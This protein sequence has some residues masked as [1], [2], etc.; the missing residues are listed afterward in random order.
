MR[1]RAGYKP[2][3]NLNSGGLYAP[4]V[5]GY[6]YAGAI[7]NVHTLNGLVGVNQAIVSKKEFR[8][9]GTN[10]HVVIAIGKQRYQNI[11][12]RFKKGYYG[13]IHHSLWQPGGNINLTRR[14][15]NC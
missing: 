10:H 7:T 12:T 1:L 13:T 4:E 8:C 3:V 15:L 11:R 6:G 2:Q 5:D 9:P 14:W